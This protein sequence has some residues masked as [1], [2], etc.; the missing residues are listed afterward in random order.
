MCSNG[1]HLPQQSPRLQVQIIERVHLARSN[2]H[3]TADVAEFRP[4]RHEDARY[5]SALLPSCPAAGHG[6]CAASVA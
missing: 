5:N 1:L 6:L 2:S 4:C 3:V